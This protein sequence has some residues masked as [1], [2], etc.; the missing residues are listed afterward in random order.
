VRRDGFEAC[1]SSKKRNEMKKNSRNRGIAGTIPPD[2]S[3]MFEV[4]LLE[5]VK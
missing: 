3:L 4:K 2:A 1:L 5:I